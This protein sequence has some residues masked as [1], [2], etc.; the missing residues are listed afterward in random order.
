LLIFPDN[1]TKYL[2]LKE[3]PQTKEGYVL[4]SAPIAELKEQNLKF[5]PVYFAYSVGMNFRD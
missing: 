4:S 3:Y 2:I 1:H 5:I